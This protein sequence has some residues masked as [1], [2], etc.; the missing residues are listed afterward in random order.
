M[1]SNKIMLDLTRFWPKEKKSLQ[2][3]V[4]A[5]RDL[6]NKKL[7]ERSLKWSWGSHNNYTM[8][9]QDHLPNTLSKQGEGGLCTQS[10]MSRPLQEEM[11]RALCLHEC[12]HA[13][14]CQHEVGAPERFCVREQTQ[15]KLTSFW[16]NSSFT[17][18]LER[19]IVVL[20]EELDGSKYPIFTHTPYT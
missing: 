20:S 15:T 7:P 2:G 8:K 19:A 13:H 9:V 17:D 10:G 18:N 16:S 12:A 4:W 11:T 1:S 3:A 6:M 14:E 5:P